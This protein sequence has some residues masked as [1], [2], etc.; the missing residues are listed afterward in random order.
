M[1]CEGCDNEM[2]YKALERVWYCLYC[3]LTQGEED[4]R[5]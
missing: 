3:H 4:A 1:I 5:I 2:I